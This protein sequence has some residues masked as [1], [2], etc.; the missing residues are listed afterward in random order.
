MG[1]GISATNLTEVETRRTG[2][3]AF[4]DTT[5]RP[6]NITDS[7]FT[8]DYSFSGLISNSISSP[9]FILKT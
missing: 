3:G 9:E 4:V 6:F 8:P 1:M 5:N 7:C 2:Y